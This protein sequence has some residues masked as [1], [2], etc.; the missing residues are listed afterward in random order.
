MQ[1]SQTHGNY[2]LKLVIGH[3]SIWV[4]FVPYHTVMTFQ[5]FTKAIF[6]RGLDGSVSPTPSCPFL[7]SPWLPWMRWPAPT[8]CLASWPTSLSPSVEM[9]DSLRTGPEEGKWNGRQLHTLPAFEWCHFPRQAP[10]WL[11]GGSFGQ[12]PP[13]SPVVKGTYTLPEMQRGRCLLMLLTHYKS[14]GCFSELHLHCELEF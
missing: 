8:H 3:F 4:A 9:A 11:R 10:H 1:S 13:P 12:W 2:V 14:S 7:S 5:S 6:L